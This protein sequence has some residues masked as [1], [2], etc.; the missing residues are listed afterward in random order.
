MLKN[1]F[2][3]LGFLHESV[4]TAACNNFPKTYDPKWVTDEIRSIKTNVCLIIYSDHDCKGRSIKVLANYGSADL[5]KDWKSTV[6]GPET[7]HRLNEAYPDYS[8]NTKSFHICNDE[9]GGRKFNLDITDYKEEFI[10]YLKPTVLLSYSNICSCNNIPKYIQNMNKWSIDNYGNSL[11]AYFEPNCGSSQYSPLWIPSGFSS[12]SMGISLFSQT[13]EFNEI[14][15]SV[16]SFGPDINSEYFQLN[17]INI[18]SSIVKFVVLE[19]G[20]EAKNAESYAESN[21]EMTSSKT[22]FRN[23]ANSQLS[24]TYSAS[25]SV[26]TLFSVDTGTNF[27]KMKRVQVD[28]S[29]DV[30][31]RKVNGQSASTSSSLAEEVGVETKAS[32]KFLGVGLEITASYSKTTGNAR[33]NS[34]SV[35][36]EAGLKEGFRKAYESSRT[37]ATEQSNSTV[38]ENTKTF[39]VSQTINVSPCT[40]QTVNAY[41]KMVTM[42]RE[43]M[44][45]AKVGGKL[46]DRVM[47]AAEVRYYMDTRTLTYISDFDAFSVW[48]YMHGHFR[49]EY[50]MSAFINSEG[51]TLFDCVSY[52]KSKNLIA[53]LLRQ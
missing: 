49:A 30:E 37:S 43:F 40:E 48:A 33:S 34:T 3:F 36:Q 42:N 45:V 26:R 6:T 21:V 13:S 11:I 28:N 5:V 15:S 12:Y 47:T 52:I 25:L 10:S 7:L 35:S 23:N 50:A 29:F 32:T 2:D 17:C 14:I 31:T 39:S 22:E 9:I 53:N 44:A 24:Q 20:N 19:P 16:E 51:N 1:N 41:V 38:V 46:G 4:S 27:N 18:Y 8:W